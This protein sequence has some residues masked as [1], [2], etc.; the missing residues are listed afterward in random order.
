MTFSVFFEFFSAHLQ[1]KTDALHLRVRSHV[2]DSAVAFLN[3]AVQIAALAEC[4]QR[5]RG[6][7]FGAPPLLHYWTHIVLE[8]RLQTFFGIDQAATLLKV[9]KLCVIHYGGFREQHL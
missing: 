6:E 2:L 3:D 7:A 4:A 9:R 5:I 8:S 1:Q